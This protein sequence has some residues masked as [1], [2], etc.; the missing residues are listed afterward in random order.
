MAEEKTPK[1]TID[2]VARV[3]GVSV[4]TVSRVLNNER[5]VR[6][7]MRKRVLDAI[8]V[9]QYRRNLYARNL[10]GDRSHIVGL[11]FDVPSGDYVSGVLRGALMK[12]GAEGFHLVVEILETPG[13]TDKMDAFLGQLRPDGVILTPPVCDDLAVLQVLK[14]QKV[15]VIR[16]APRAPFAG[17]ASVGIDDRKAAFDM[18]AYLIGLGH[19]AIGFIKGDPDHGGSHDRFRGFQDALAAHG[20]RQA[21]ALV[22]QGFFSFESGL[23]CAR[24]LLDLP[25]P[26]TAIFASNDEMAAGVIALAHQRGIAVPDELSVAGFDDGSIAS[27]VWPSLTTIRQPTEAI[28]GAAIGCLMAMRDEGQPADE[29]QTVLDFELIERKST[30]APLIP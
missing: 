28:A 9:L 29:T 10:A 16:I 26:P 11:F 14:K 24:R 8:S 27:W 19:R 1:A 13:L 17:A 20:L 22:E 18:T 25:N 7:T 15:P 2:D 30:A 6:E 23:E 4:S 12:C 21:P 5:Y 3:A